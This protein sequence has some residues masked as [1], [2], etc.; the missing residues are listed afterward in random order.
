MKKRFFSLLILT[1][2]FSSIGF[3]QGLHI[4]V[5]GGANIFKVDGKQFEDEYKF[6]YNLG[7]FAEIGLSPKWVIQPE[8]MWNQ[9][10]FRTG[11]EFDDLYTGGVNNFKGKLNYLSIPLLLSFKPSKILTLQAGPQFGILLNKEEDLLDTGEQAFKSGDFSMLG[12]VQLNIGGAKIGGRYVVGL[13]NI[14]DLPQKEKWKNQG[15]Q[16]YVGFRII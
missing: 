4:G 5:K 2:L 8:V 15:F 7:A 1:T 16:L 6:G 11:S 9:T 13:A 12:G 14:N 3:A 10:N